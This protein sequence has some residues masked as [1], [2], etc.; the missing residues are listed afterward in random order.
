MSVIWVNLSYDRL[1][2]MILYN[3]Q[4]L[5]HIEINKNNINKKK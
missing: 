4:N 3:K 5:T 2:Y 1:Q